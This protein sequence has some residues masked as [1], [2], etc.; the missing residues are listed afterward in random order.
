M[1][2][3]NGAFDSN[4]SRNPSPSAREASGGLTARPQVENILHDPNLTTTHP[5]ATETTET[6]DPTTNPNDGSSKLTDDNEERAGLYDFAEELRNCNP[7][8]EP[9][10]LE[11]SRLRGIYILWLNKRLA[12]SRK[13][14]LERQ[15]P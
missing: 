12:M 7:P 9:W 1:S 3:P 8:V 10:F 5:S 11:N 6:Q 14:I 15:Q 2:S 4:S 13:D